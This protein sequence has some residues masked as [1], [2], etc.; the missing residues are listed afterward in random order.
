MKVLHAG[1]MVNFAY[2]FVK[3]LRLDGIDSDLLM[4]TNP[5]PS[6][7]PK[8]YDSFLISSISFSDK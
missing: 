4:N 8:L 1:N 3:K 7:D 2:Q 5:H 6:S